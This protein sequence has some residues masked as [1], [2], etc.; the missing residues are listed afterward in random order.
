MQ[1]SKKINRWN[2]LITW[3]NAQIAFKKA[4]MSTFMTQNHRLLWY[5]P[6]YFLS[7]QLSIR[8]ESYYLPD[9]FITRSVEIMG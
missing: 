1:A 3:E 5:L 6:R 4:K 8:D 2:L 9:Y 7:A